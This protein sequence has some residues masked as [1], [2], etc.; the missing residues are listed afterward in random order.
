MMSIPK[1][2]VEGN[3]EGEAGAKASGL[4]QW[5]KWKPASGL[6]MAA[7]V[8]SVPGCS[9]E[10]TPTSGCYTYDEGDGGKGC[11]CIDDGVASAGTVTS[12]GCLAHVVSAP[13]GGSCTMPACI[14]V[15]G[16]ALLNAGNPAGNSF[17]VGPFTFRLDLVGTVNS[18]ET[19][20]VDVLDI[21][22]NQLQNANL[23]ANDS[24]S[25]MEADGITKVTVSMV[26][27]GVESSSSARVSGTIKCETDS[28][29]SASNADSGGKYD[30]APKDARKDSRESDARM[31]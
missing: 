2:K 9:S 31:D 23:V 10:S 26:E 5:S 13:D 29:A 12:S 14:E 17:S 16:S 30:A 7:A 21:C 28:G 19:G 8:A 6:L 24:K 1:T 3:R 20:S 27:L 25:F 4:S 22:G 18:V 15:N 11:Y